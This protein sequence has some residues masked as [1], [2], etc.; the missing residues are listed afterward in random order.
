M[1]VAIVV[2]E[3]DDEG[4]VT[5]VLHKFTDEKKL[6]EF[7]ENRPE[8]ASFHTVDCLVASPPPEDHN[9]NLTWCAYCS[10]SRNFVKNFEHDT[11]NCLICGVSDSDYYIRKF[12]GRN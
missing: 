1:T 11:Y 2:V 10:E 7:W 5:R 8:G 9:R 4:R 6:R 12:N 3:R